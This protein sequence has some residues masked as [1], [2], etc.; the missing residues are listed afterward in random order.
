MDSDWSLSWV[1]IKFLL[2]PILGEKDP[3]YELFIRNSCSEGG[4]KRQKETEMIQLEKVFN[5]FF[6]AMKNETKPII[7]PWQEHGG[8]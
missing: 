6:R 4:E 5:I 3:F 7:C 8:N 2:S 1:E